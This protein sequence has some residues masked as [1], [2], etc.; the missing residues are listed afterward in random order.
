MARPWSLPKGCVDCDEGNFPR[1]WIGFKRL[2]SRRHAHPTAHE[3]LQALL[4]TRTL[5][6]TH[7]ES[8]VLALFTALTK[9]NGR[10]SWIWSASSALRVAQ[11]AG[12]SLAAKA[13]AASW[14]VPLFRIDFGAL[15]D[16]WQGESERKLREALR[17]ADAMRPCVL[18]MD[19]IE[20]GLAGGGGTGAGQACSARC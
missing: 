13:I 14:Q 17:V 2:Q 9:N 10:E 16:K 4:D 5:I 6:E 1:R 11:G 12:K 15:Y 20:K 3:F 8:R 7:D 19:E 18:W